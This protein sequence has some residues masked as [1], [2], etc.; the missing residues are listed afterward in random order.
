MAP[1]GSTSNYSGH[2]SSGCLKGELLSLRRFANF[3]GK[4]PLLADGKTAK[5]Y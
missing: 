3:S 5:S 2:K 1:K 4:W